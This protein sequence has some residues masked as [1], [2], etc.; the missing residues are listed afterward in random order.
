M[1]IIGEDIYAAQ[2]SYGPQTAK[3]MEVLDYTKT[4]KI[5]ALTENGVV[6]DIDQMIMS[7]TRWAWFNTW[8]GDFV[9]K[10]GRYSEVYT[11]AEL[12]KKVY[13]SEYVITRDE[14][15]DFN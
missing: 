13:D 8:C 11:E 1:D 15:P 10:N 7:G 3:F 4:N 6:P 9:Q 5:I 12:L 2:R 14:L